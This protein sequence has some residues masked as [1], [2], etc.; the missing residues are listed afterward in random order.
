MFKKQNLTLV[1]III[2]LVVLVIAAVGNTSFFFAN[3]RNL[4]SALQRRSATWAALEKMEELISIS[5]DDLVGKNN[6]DDPEN[7][8]LLENHNAT[9]TVEVLDGDNELYKKVTVTVQ[10][11]DSSKRFVTYIADY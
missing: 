3:R 4:R 10:W 11:N 8:S 5:F 2:A 9:R 6:T 7:I 1:E